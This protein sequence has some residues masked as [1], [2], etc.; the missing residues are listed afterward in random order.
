MQI[1]HIRARVPSEH[2]VVA[3]G[4]IL[5]EVV[6]VAVPQRLGQFVERVIAQVGL[7][8][9]AVSNGSSCICGSIDAIGSGTE[10]GAIPH[11]LVAMQ[12]LRHQQGQVLTP[13]AQSLAC[14][15]VRD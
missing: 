1:H 14:D 10:E 11:S 9:R 7:N 6:A 5:V 12:G 3:A 13:A 15:L 2:V 4:E 8:H